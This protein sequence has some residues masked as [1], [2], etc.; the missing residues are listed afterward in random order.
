MIF[1]VLPT[2]ACIFLSFFPYSYRVSNPVCSSHAVEQMKVNEL[3]KIHEHA[4]FVLHAVASRSLKVHVFLAQRWQRLTTAEYQA[5][6][7]MIL[8][9]YTV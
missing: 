3:V 6:H 5:R 9:C 8:Q 7:E 1:T 4:K 2:R